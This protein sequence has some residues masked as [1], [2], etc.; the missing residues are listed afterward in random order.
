MRRWFR[1]FDVHDVTVPGNFNPVFAL[2]W[3]CIE[4]LTATNGNR[5]VASAT[6]QQLADFWRDPATHKGPLWDAFV[7]LPDQWQRVLAAGF[8]IEATRPTEGDPT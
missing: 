6:V 2:G 3:Q 1:D 5:I 8:Y 7:Q 4:L